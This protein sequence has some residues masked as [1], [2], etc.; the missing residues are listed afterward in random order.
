MF[1]LEPSDDLADLFDDAPC[2]YVSLSPDGR[3]ARINRTLAIW[4]GG[5][6]EELVGRRFETCLGFG[7]RI[8][9]E[10]HLAPML[11]LNSEISD[12]AMDLIG[13]NG[14]KIPVIASA[15]ESRSQDGSHL[16]TRVTM[17]KSAGRQL[18]ERML[19]ADRDEARAELQIGQETATLREQFIAVLGHD[20]RNPLAALGAGTRLLGS[21]TLSDRG[22][23]IVTEMAASVARANLL[24]DNVLDFARGRLGEGL[25]LNRD[26]NAPLTPVLEQIVAEVRAITPDRVINASFRIREPVDCDRQRIGQLAANLISNAISHGTADKPIEVEAHSTDGQFVFSVTNCGMPIPA[27]ARARLFQPFFRGDVKQS[28]QGLG[29][30]L[31]IV[32]EIAKAH[33]GAMDVQSD[34][35]ATCLRL[36]MPQ[37]EN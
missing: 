18:H 25:I 14:V 24:I 16:F 28:Q 30:G 33:G 35:A 3:I 17:F 23:F 15:R 32:S 27:A 7:G 26:A 6:A 13:A 36:V 31:F 8:A 5:S 2:G 20:L 4:L 29:L 12:V 37:P 10:T 21:E 22:H 19:T 1:E 34:D 9:F 11:R